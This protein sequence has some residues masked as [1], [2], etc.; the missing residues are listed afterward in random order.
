MS[1]VK[2]HELRNRIVFTILV[3][4]V[5]VTGKGV[6]LF[7]VD[8]SVGSMG[9][10]T[11][12]MVTM[13]LSGDRFQTTIMALGV[14][15]YINASLLIQ[16]VAA[17][18]STDA[19]AKISKLK[20]DR[21]TLIATFIF[22][23][24]LAFIQSGELNYAPSS[25]NPLLV[26][27]IVFLE[28]LGG[29]MLAFFLCMKNEKYGIGFSMPIILVNTITSLQGSLSQYHFFRYPKLVLICIAVIA[30]TI[31]MENKI[32]KIPLQ[33]VS[34]HNIHAD[35][36]YIAYKY[37][38]IG[39]MPV[40]F[41]TAAFILPRLILRGLSFAFP[42]N[43]DIAAIRSDMVMTKPL[44]IIVYLAII[45][46]LTQVLSYIMISPKESARQLQKNGDSI[47]GIYAG[48]KTMSYLVRIV[49]NLSFLS[50]FLQAGCMSI[51]LILA[52]DNDIPTTLA[53]IPSA[54][55]IMVS[56]ICSL[57]QEI[58]SYRLYDAYS[59]FF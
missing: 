52:M 51:S 9:V 46:L 29:A 54:A 7:G 28:M 23:L 56:I 42:Q 26:R 2:T 59:F 44:G 25:L 4:A 21:W 24:I 12:S 43:A 39:I 37:N 5:Y 30:L 48:K 34:I 1:Q 14:I 53:M 45:I 13:M 31:F 19:R 32:V 8:P 11:Q 36:N 35:Q 10:N 49:R 58:R 40:M 55:M 20:M 27:S 47:I 22:A 33:R 16:I 3:I 41:A 17:L 18:A 6:E 50:G 38:P 15:P 57:V